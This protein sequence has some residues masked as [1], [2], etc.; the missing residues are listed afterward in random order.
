MEGLDI[1]LEQKDYKIELLEN[2]IGLPE[3][4]VIEEM[5]K[6]GLN[7]ISSEGQVDRVMD[8]LN[9]SLNNHNYI[10]NKRQ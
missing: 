10:K 7:K 5:N 4:K 2:K 3:C 9:N 6:L 1:K 8:R